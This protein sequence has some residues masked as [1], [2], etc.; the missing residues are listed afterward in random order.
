[1]KPE[2]FIH[3][4]IAVPADKLGGLYAAVAALL[5]STA[6]AAAKPGNSG[7]GAGTVSAGTVSAGTPAASGA[8]P[9]P[10]PA[11]AS[12]SAGPGPSATTTVSPSDGSEVDA[13]G[14]PWD[15]NRHAATKSKTKAGLWRMKVGVNRPENEGETSADYRNPEGAPAGSPPPPPPTSAPAAAE[16]DEFAAFRNA[17]TGNPPPPPPAGA[18]TWT[19]ADL[20]KLCNQAALAS[21]SPEKVKEIIAK[22]VGSEVAHSRNV[23]ADQRENFAQE[24]ELAF[25]IQYAND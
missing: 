18:R 13:A 2:D 17:A 23:P 4:S 10:T 1:M 21:N 12:P 25:G 22:Y 24:V 9:A 5:G 3:V 19:D 16:D 7:S 15:A 8:I 11:A 20:S 6:V 14:V